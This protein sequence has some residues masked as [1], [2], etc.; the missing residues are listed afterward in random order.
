MSVKNEAGIVGRLTRKRQVP[1]VSG[2][3]RVYV[4]EIVETLRRAVEVRAG[5]EHEAV[6]I[7]RNGYD[8][9]DYVLGAE[10]FVGA[11]FAVVNDSRYTGRNLG[12]AR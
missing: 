6:E 5:S 2:G 1:T 4:V 9:E 7:V 10:D 8:R 11:D 3:A 12:E